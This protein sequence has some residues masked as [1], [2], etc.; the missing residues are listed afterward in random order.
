MM[1]RPKAMPDR[2]GQANRGGNI[3]LSAADS[4]DHLGSPGKLSGDGRGKRTASPMQALGL[5]SLPR[6]ILEP[7]AIEEDIDRWP[8][9]MSPLDHNMPCPLSMN[10][11][12]RLLHLLHIVNR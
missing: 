12:R 11:A 2:L 5:D 10:T 3:G 8:I 6:K 9:E 4:V 7:L 1:R